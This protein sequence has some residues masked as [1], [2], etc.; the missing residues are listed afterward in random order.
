MMDM[1]PPSSAPA[2]PPPA[3]PA[4]AQPAPPT[5]GGLM[6]TEEQIAQWKQR[7]DAALRVI[8]DRRTTSWRKNITAYMGRVLDKLPKDHVVNVL[9]EFAFVESKKAQL[10]FQVPEV[11]LAPQLPGLEAAVSVFQPALNHELGDHGANVKQCVD[12]I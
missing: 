2:M 1:V 7:K 6:L 10:A 11:H 12:E 9:L 4:P 8:E 3:A 5:G